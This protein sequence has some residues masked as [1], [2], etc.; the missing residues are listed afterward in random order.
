MAN[1]GIYREAAAAGGLPL[2]RARLWPLTIVVGLVALAATVMPLGLLVVAGHGASGA[3]RLFRNGGWPMW[4]ILFSEVVAPVAIAVLGAFVMRGK[5]V[6]AGLVFVAAAMPFAVALL[7]A[8]VGQRTT[9]GAISGVSVDPEQ[10]ARILAEGV[11]ETMSNDVFGGFVACGAAIAATLAAASLAASIDVGV[12]SRGGAKPSAFGAIGA[13][14]CG[15]LWLVASLVIGGLRLRDMGPI[16]LLPALPLFV[17]VPFAALAGR[18]A[19]VVRGW[20][21]R[22]EGSRVAGAL[23]VAAASAL[24]AVLA[25]QR[26]IE[27]SFTSRAL[28]AISGESIDPSQRMR[29]LAYAV[30]AG[31]LAPAAYAVHAILGTA[32]LGLALAPALG[33]GKHPATPS[34]LGAV[35]IGLALLGG[36]LALGHS[37]ASIPRAFAEAATA[38]MPAGVS[39][40]VTMETFSN[41][42]SGTAYGTRIIVAKDGTGGETPSSWTPGHYTIYADKAATL[43]MVRSR[44]P[45]KGGTSEVTFVALRDHPPDIEARLGYLAGY[46]GRVGYVAATLDDDPVGAASY[47]TLRVVSVADDA[48]EIDGK[49]QPFPIPET[50]TVDGSYTRKTGIRYVFRPG[51]TVDRAVQTI[52]GVEKLYAGRIYTSGLERTIVVD[53][54]TWKPKVAD[55]DA[56]GGLGGSFAGG[57]GAKAPS[58][59]AGA[60]TVNG[61]LPPEVI[62]RIVRQNFG[63]YRLCYENGLRSDPSLHGRVTVRFV[64]D[65]S[66][67]VQKATDGGST[68]PDKTVVACVVRGFGNLSFPQP[69]GG[70]VTV[71]Y[72][73]EFTQAK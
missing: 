26:G 40:P 57:V 36:A 44:L 6:P 34:A 15:A 31:R 53:D 5:R 7:G 32:T 71:V 11:A 25:L 72:P 43:A 41:R 18:G 45:R 39:L 29:I 58:L 48:V 66:G 67:A 62:Q 8:W 13:G 20:H 16:A 22:A 69:E 14:A 24:L 70:I 46:L 49:R 73:I 59:R 60:A 65:R 37:R 52:A 54:G 23:L 21:D 55:S 4:L 9:I 1:Q 3:W 68:L 28:E 27:A 12:A 56:F 61:R 30:D 47:D 35:A 42:G 33:A 38:S 2:P 64:I 10:K 51:D 17:I 19:G 50:A 63:R